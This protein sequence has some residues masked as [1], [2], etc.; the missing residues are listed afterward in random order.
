MT[1]RRCGRAGSRLGAALTALAALAALAAL[2]LGDAARA[3][4]AA[5][6][7]CLDGGVAAWRS[8]GLALCSRFARK[9][10][11][12]REQA[13]ALYASWVGTQRAGF[14]PRCAEMFETV[15]C[16]PCDP[17]VGLGRKRIIC[18]STCDAW[19]DA[20]K[21]EFFATTSAVAGDTLVPCL[22]DAVVCSQL[23]D[24]VPS[25][26]A[27]CATYGLSLGE[28]FCYDGS[29][30]PEAVGV[31]D[32]SKSSSP[33]SSRSFANFRRKLYRYLQSQGKAFMRLP[34]F[35]QGLALNDISI[36]CIRA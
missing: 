25:G 10:C 36:F 7:S 17:E 14:A 35:Q 27:L 5:G 3:D 18:K 20:C 30:D 28:D 13:A 29:V 31:K 24:F 16:M 21:D 8:G 15:M 33:S 12:S 22:Q 11:C 6:E 32:V 34:P 19:F 2:V 1:A 4:A 26:T 23:A 9:T